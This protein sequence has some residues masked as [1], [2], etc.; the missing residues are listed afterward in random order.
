MYRSILIAVVA[1]GVPITS[2]PHRLAAQTAHGDDTLVVS[3]AD[4]RAMAVRKNP[5]LRA[6]SWSPVAARGDA[7]SARTLPFNPEVAFEARSP[8]SGVTSRFEAELG[9]EL[10]V[11]G[12]AGLRVEASEAAYAASTRRFQ[13]D[14]RRV[15]AEVERAY[16]RLVAAEQRQDLADEIS[17]LNA[18]LGEAVGTQ[19]AEGEVSVLEANLASIEAARA[20]ARALEARG[21][22]S[23]AALR[24]ARLL[25]LEAGRPLRT[26]G[27][28]PASSSPR[29][30][31]IEVLEEAVASR[32][33]LVAADLEVERARQAAR[34]ASRE[35][36]PNLRVA[37]LATRE[38]PALDPRLGMSV[39]LELPLFN[40]N[41]GRSER[42][43]AELLR[44]EEER[45]ATRL[46]VE[47]EVEDALRS[48]EL[49]AREVEMLR[50]EMLDPIRQNRGLLEI[51]YREG[52]IDLASLLLLRNQLLDA[53]LAYWAAWERREVARTELASATGR[54]LEGVEL[55]EGTER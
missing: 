22:R 53:E 3:L 19:L 13:D 11:A 38:N 14:G 39:G 54:I 37:A 48:Y 2:G 32:P 55:T 15:L 16:H 4:V 31:E 33:D 44:S 5:R 26:E 17:R 18:R 28:A 23:T 8:G 10:E 21:E 20:R 45:K 12:Q 27:P 29:G 35:A 49:A 46:R 9:L 52:K 34:L 50:D 30:G 51:A 24:V 40:R 1:V 6:S 25:G 36:F 41:Q 7:R 47:V 43:R 42:R